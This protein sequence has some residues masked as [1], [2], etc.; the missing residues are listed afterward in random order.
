MSIQR[1]YVL[2]ALLVVAFAVRE[3]AGWYRESKVPSGAYLEV[4]GHILVLPSGYTFS[5]SRSAS[6]DGFAFVPYHLK[7]G[8]VIVGPYTALSGS[9][10]EWVTKSTT[11]TEERCGVHVIQLTDQG[12]TSTFVHDSKEYVLFA[13]VPPEDIEFSLAAFCR[14]GRAG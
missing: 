9:F 4:F 5:V 7:T 3:G 1:P 11:K 6:S 13:G 8:K 10:H 2:L 12:K 14:V